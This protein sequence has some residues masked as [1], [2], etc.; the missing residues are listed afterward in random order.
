MTLKDW[1]QRLRANG[2]SSEACL[3]TIGSDSKLLRK[4]GALHLSNSDCFRLLVMS[5]VFASM[6]IP[7]WKTPRDSPQFKAWFWMIAVHCS[8]M[9]IKPWKCWLSSLLTNLLARDPSFS[10]ASKISPIP[11][12]ETKPYEP[13]PENSYP[14]ISLHSRNR[15]LPTANNLSRLNS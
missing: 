2:L 5:A 8:P 12:S 7:I 14:P 6:S 11:C 3:Q 10:P 9:K 13:S 4:V 15:F 1:V